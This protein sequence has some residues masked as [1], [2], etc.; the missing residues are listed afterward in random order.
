MPSVVDTS[1][2]KVKVSSA[3]EKDYKLSGAGKSLLP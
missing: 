1:S 2:P 3:R